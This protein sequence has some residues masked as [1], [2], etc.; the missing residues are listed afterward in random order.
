[1]DGSCEGD[2][3]REQVVHSPR[4][5]GSAGVPGGTGS[6]ISL[7]MTCAPQPCRRGLAAEDGSRGFDVWVAGSWS[8]RP[9]V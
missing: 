4:E 8:G 9:A 6:Q 2:V 3:W 7:E 1:M 5:A